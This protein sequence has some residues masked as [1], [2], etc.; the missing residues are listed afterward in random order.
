MVSRV[1]L[2]CYTGESIVLWFTCLTSKRFLVHIWEKT[3]VPLWLQQVDQTSKDH[4]V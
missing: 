4:G 2:N 3:Q 1:V